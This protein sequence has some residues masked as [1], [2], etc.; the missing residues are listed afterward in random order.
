MIKK[1]IKVTKNET[2]YDNNNFNNNELQDSMKAVIEKQF[3]CAL[4]CI[5]KEK[6]SMTKE[7]KKLEDSLHRLK[8]EEEK[9]KKEM[10]KLLNNITNLIT[11]EGKKHEI[12]ITKVSEPKSSLRWNNFLSTSHSL[13][14]ND[15]RTI[16]IKKSSDFAHY[17]CAIGNQSVRRFT[18]KIEEHIWLRIGLFIV[19]PNDQSNFNTSLATPSSPS[20]ALNYSA[21]SSSTS[22]TTST[23][24]YPP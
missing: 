3:Q 5:T 6:E 14:F 8:K 18:I 23:S 17:S 22:S 15:N 2:N 21:S 12:V 1:E 4:Q 10:F 9:N 11:I 7:I 20:T 24:C 19:F 16:Q 13:Y